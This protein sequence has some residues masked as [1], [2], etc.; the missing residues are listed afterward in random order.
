MVQSPEE[1]RSERVQGMGSALGNLHFLLWTELAWL[2]VKWKEFKT[3]FASSDE[4]V[5]ILNSIAPAFF[6]HV[7]AVLWSDILLHVCR[8]SDPA[9]LGTKENLTVQRL[10][11]EIPDSDAA[12]RSDVECLLRAVRSGT[13][14]ARDWRNRE[15][16]HRDHERALNPDLHPLLPAT[17]NSVESALEAIAAVLNRVQSTVMHTEARYGDTIEP[18][19]G[20]GVLL[21]KLREYQLCH[22]DL[23]RS[24]AR[25]STA[26]P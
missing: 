20:A 3:L 23:H 13:E 9:K 15:L 26:G 17:C 2:N 8:I 18:L 25:A 21:R 14:F 16:A 11:E 12:L 19:G 5:E 7:Q 22:L 24:D 10:T 4:D 6:G 1:V